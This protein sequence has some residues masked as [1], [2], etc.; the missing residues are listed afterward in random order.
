VAVL[1]AEL[2]EVDRFA[3]TDQVIAYAGL[4]ILIK[5][6]G[7]W[8]GQAKLSKRGSRLLRQ[9]LYLAASRSIHLEG[10]AFGSDSSRLVERGL[11]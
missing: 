3:R 2:G 7:L 9:M 5:E 8:K 10:S 4:D 1:R 11:I 6:S